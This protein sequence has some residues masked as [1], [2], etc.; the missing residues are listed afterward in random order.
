MHKI[1]FFLMLFL[2][3][4]NSFA[5]GLKGIYY[6]ND[7]YCADRKEFTRRIDPTI[8]FF[9][10]IKPACAPFDSIGSTNAAKRNDSWGIVWSGYI[11]IPKNKQLIINRGTVTTRV[12]VDENTKFDTNS[13]GCGHPLDN[14]KTWSYNSA[15]DPNTKN[16]VKLDKLIPGL[17]KIKIYTYVGVPDCNKRYFSLMFK[18]IDPN[19]PIE[20]VPTENLFPYKMAEV[21][22]EKNFYSLNE[23]NTGNKIIE[24]PINLST[25]LKDDI[26]IKFNTQ[27]ETATNNIDYKILNDTITIPTNETKAILK[28]EIL[29]NY[30]NTNTRKTFNVQISQITPS[31]STESITGEEIGEILKQPYDSTKIEIISKIMTGECLQENP[32]DKSPAGFGWK[33][34]SAYTSSGKYSGYNDYDAEADYRNIK[35]DWNTE[36]RN[37]GTK[38]LTIHHGAPSKI[39]GIA[40]INL[41]EDGKGINIS[42]NKTVIEFDYYAW[43]GEKEPYSPYIGEII[44]N[45]V[46]INTE[47][48]KDGGL[49]MAVVL[50]DASIDE[51]RLAEADSIDI[52]PGLGYLSKNTKF[53]N[54]L[55]AIGIHQAQDFAQ[56]ANGLN[57]GQNNLSNSITIRGSVDKNAPFIISKQT[58]KLGDGNPKTDDY[59]A[60]RFKITLDSTTGNTLISVSR[61]DKIIIDKQDIT[62][63]FPKSGKFK[64]AFAASTKR[65]GYSN[66]HQIANVSIKST[67]CSFSKQETYT[68][69][70]VERQFAQAH[71]ANKAKYDFNW[72]YNSP[73]RTKI[74]GGA[75]LQP[76]EKNSNKIGYEYCVIGA[77]VEEGNAYPSTQPQNVYV[78]YSKIDD[79]ELLKYKLDNK[80]NEDDLNNLYSNEQNLTTGNFPINNVEKEELVYSDGKDNLEL[81]TDPNDVTAACFVLHKNFTSNNIT[82]HM[83]FNAYDLSIKSED[84][85]KG[86]KSSNN[87]FAIKPAGFYM[88][89][90]EI[91]YANFPQRTPKLEIKPKKDYT[92]ELIKTDDNNKINMPIKFFINDANISILDSTT[93]L[94]SSSIY[95]VNATPMVLNIS[96]KK[97]YKYTYTLANSKN[98]NYYNLI[99]A[100]QK[101]DPV[102]NFTLLRAITNNYMNCENDEN[103]SLG[104]NSTINP[105]ILRITFRDSQIKY[106]NQTDSVKENLKINGILI[107]DSKDLYLKYDNVMKFENLFKDPYWTAINFI[108]IYNNNKNKLTAE[109]KIALSQNLKNYGYQCRPD[110]DSQDASKDFVIN[111]EFADEL[112]DCSI[113]ALNPKYIEFIPNNFD[114]YVTRILNQSNINKEP[115]KGGFTYYNDLMQDVNKT[116]NNDKNKLDI[117][118]QMSAKLQLIIAA[119]DENGNSY[120]NFTNSCYA[121]DIILNLSYIGDRNFKYKENIQNNDVKTLSSKETSLMKNAI[122][123]FN[124]T[125]DNYK[126]NAHL[127]KNINQK[128]E[129]RKYIKYKEEN[130]LSEDIKDILKKESIS[131]DKQNSLDTDKISFNVA[132]FYNQKS[133][134]NFCKD[135]NETE[136]CFIKIISPYTTDTDINRD[137]KENFNTDRNSYKTKK[138]KRGDVEEWD[139]FTFA[140]KTNDK[141]DDKSTLVQIS[142]NFFNDNIEFIDKDYKKQ[143]LKRTGA[144]S[145]MIGFNIER[146]ETPMNPT[147][148]FIRDFIP[149][150]LWLVSDENRLEIKDKNVEDPFNIPTK[151]NIHYYD[152][153]DNESALFYYGSAYAKDAKGSRDGI[154]HIIDYTAYCTKN[155][156]IFDINTSHNNMVLIPHWYKTPDYTPTVTTTG[157]IYNFTSKEG[158]TTTTSS[159]DKY[160]QNINIKAPD[161]KNVDSD[162]ITFITPTYLKYQNTFGVEFI[163]DNENLWFGDG[164]VGSAESDESKN[165]VGKVLGTDKDN[166]FDKN[167]N[168]NSNRIFW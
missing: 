16:G 156:D 37:N 106:Q 116:Y 91:D 164:S 122:T 121:K 123:A 52:L 88:T 73:L 25:Q 33:R 134:Q 9:W 96:N 72:L 145:V 27:D 45:K 110:I 55:L 144:T 50:Y 128:D 83:Y 115:L 24:I 10:N 120:P 155:C 46:S 53:T 67:D 13:N 133:S 140:D 109:E 1:I 14:S 166:K 158:S 119:S 51:P 161:D 8:D 101:T 165:N 40:N 57:G 147:K 143:P 4:I 111:N 135:T 18:D 44:R 58:D 151:I 3:S 19:V 29:K 118:N 117:E 43:G 92:K 129:F 7:P 35:I 130:L 15:W 100:T 12:A 154:K 36:A 84:I 153:D 105:D 62:S 124:T 26:T 11:N 146:N 108:D 71:K 60:G 56:N 162:T 163:K 126:E 49:G 79:K 47:T 23:P 6:T 90:E 125:S 138:V 41:G 99:E 5:I 114:I 131:L 70:V 167:L 149:N 81:T 48:K 148:I 87:P 38:R 28:V 93:I 69:K 168:K 82:S 78:T 136:Q 160:A 103:L 64:V 75:P 54:G 85:L 2:T 17:H 112:V 98:T 152:H 42:K 86:I 132:G 68:L 150:S 76:Y 39:G 139:S 95:K 141:F 107:N 65:T 66:V 22:F 77:K 32:Q 104:K 31:K 127:E 157:D 89:F 159:L 30:K 34:I 80:F 21:S 61:D 20:P 97:D 94:N 102:Y 74:A 63:Y 113:Q 137:E 59:H 142:K